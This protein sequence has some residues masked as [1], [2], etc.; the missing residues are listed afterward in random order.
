MAGSGR[1]WANGHAVALLAGVVAAATGLGFWFNAVVAFPLEDDA[2]AVV[3]VYPPLD[4]VGV[5]LV[6]AQDG[7]LAITFSEPVTL[8][9]GAVELSCERSLDHVVVTAGGPA[10]FSFVSDRLF[11]PGEVCRMT[12]RA[13]LIGDVDDDDPPDSPLSDVS[14]TFRTA[15]EPVIINELD[16][17]SA[18]GLGEFVELYDGGHGDTD[19]SGLTV[20]FYR[21]DEAV[22]YL[23]VALDDYRTNAAGYFVLGD[24]GIPGADLPLANGTL[25]DGPDAVAVY[26]APK[27]NFPRNTP[28]TTENLMD[29]VVYGPADAA[30]LVLLK[31][32]QAS[33]DEGGRGAATTDSLQRCPNGSGKPRETKAF[34]PN[35]PTP[36][37]S[38]RCSFDAAPS[39]VATTPL[40]GAASVPIDTS[41]GVDFSEAVTLASGAVAIDCE[42]SGSH[43]YAQS[44]SG[45][46]YSFKPDEPFV[47]GETCAVAI[48]AEL[49]SDNDV[50]DPPDYLGADVVWSFETI[51]PAADNVLIN[52]VDADTPG[53][54][55]VEFIELYDGGEG[56]TP[57]DGLVVVLVNGGDDSSYLTVSLDGYSTDA[58][59][60]FLLANVAVSG[61]GVTLVDGVLQNGPDAVVLVEGRAVDFP[62]GTP[63]GS[64]TPL[65]AFVY[66]RPDQT[67]TGLQLLLNAG[68]PQIDEN[69][70]G[71]GDSHSNQRCPN[72]AGGA[73]NTIGYRQNTPTPGTVNNCVTDTAPAISTM[74]PDRGATGVSIFTTVTVEFTESVSLAS[75]WLTIK[76]DNSGTHSYRT[77]GGPVSFSV[78]VDTALSY[79][80]KCT[81][82]VEAGKVADTDT[83]D[84]PDTMT[85]KV[86]WSFTT[87]DAPADFILINEVDADTP[88]SDTAEFIELFDGGV[89]NTVLDGLALVLFNG[90]DVL[91]YQAVDLDGYKTDAAGYFVI[92]NATTSPD[93]LLGNG[94]LQNGPDAAAIYVADAS[95]FPNGSLIKIAGLV[96]ALVYGDPATVPVAL[97]N[98]LAD[99]QKAVNEG[100]RGAADL[101]SMQRCPNGSGGARITESYAINS[102]MPGEP[103]SCEVD[104]PP[105][106]TGT[107][108]AGGTVD[109]S[110]YSSPEVSFSEPVQLTAGAIQLNCDPGGGRAIGI[111]G[112][113]VVFGIAPAQPLPYDAQC[114]VKISASGVTD[115]DA[116]D[117]P[118][119]MDEDYEWS[120]TTSSPPPDFVVINELDSDNPG[121][122]KAEFIELFDGGA[123]G[124]D[125]SGLV[126]VLYNGQDDRSYYAIDLDGGRTNE[127]G[128]LIIGN[129]GVVGISVEIPNSMLQNGPDAV[130]LYAGDATGFPNGTPIQLAGLIDAVV[131]G[132]ADPTDTGLLLL[133]ENGEPQVDEAAGGAADLHSIGRC[134]DG[135]GGKR[136]TSAIRIAIPSPGLANNCAMDAAPAVVDVKPPDGVGDVPVNAAI[137][138]EFSEAVTV[139]PGWV[140]ID[141][142]TSGEHSAQTEGGAT[143]F[144]ALPE[145]PLLPGERCAVTIRATAVAD[146]DNDDPPDNLASDFTWYFTTAVKPADFILINEMDADTPGA[147]EAEFIELYDGGVGN[148]SL[149]GLVV[150][151]WNGT[152]ENVYRAFDLDGNSTNGDGFFTLGNIAV[153]PGLVFD[154]DT[155]QNGPDA[156]TLFTG[157]ATDFPPGTQ[158]TTDDLIDAIVYGPEGEQA[159]ALLLLLSS[160]QLPVDEG[161]LGDPDA[162]S[163]QRCPDGSGGPRQTAGYRVAP[164]TPGGSNYCIVDDAPRVVDH[165]PVSGATDVALDATIVISFSEPVFTAAGWFTIDCDLSGAHAAAVTGGPSS[166]TLTPEIGF[167]PDEVCAV[168]VDRDAVKDADADDP[169]DGMI[170]DEVW[171][172][173]TRLPLPSAGFISNSPV[174]IGETVIFTNTSVGPGSLSFVWEFGDGSPL[175]NETNPSRRYASIGSYTV[176]LTVHGSTGIARYTALVEVR[177]RQ[178][179][180]GVVVR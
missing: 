23:A 75:K 145:V 156:V 93:L 114:R 82:T 115:V 179:Y 51:S 136:R 19:L 97:L 56:H 33:L 104:E 47:R 174:R 55:K 42:R 12:A 18:A 177:S 72:G 90:S 159:T 20:V 106:V 139:E 129:K 98:L 61:L 117:P 62:N 92:G 108:P 24:A 166:F 76:C 36:G 154:E 44:G 79:A 120:F 31:S 175:S 66:G 168:T 7:S 96:D 141:C 40:S 100:G 111:T 95:Q 9:A 163:L 50:E 28:V 13:D 64:I 143:Q 84:P 167:S 172:F 3:S 105:R 43:T 160:G 149:D 25:L 122:D 140:S 99:G 161:R 124:T 73:R 147:D 16:A 67:D 87:A 1:G 78:E 113:P 34:K 110:P 21:G 158:L 101:H 131:Y 107:I 8:G 2:P 70:R 128:F 10:I 22:V 165:W 15:A 134:P 126:L 171:T 94:S 125:L 14:S 59:G 103:N 41:I 91:S 77:T 46:S 109:V 38:N 6:V 4:A 88:G 127:G 146:L 89:G 48:H 135:G 173:H 132:T 49:V 118:D 138:V 169:P 80:E 39:V 69:G 112:G 148:T 57:L 45:I 53:V 170:T 27:S 119:G 157:T 35:T 178:L 86:S 116:S 5:P 130:A 155:L 176:T 81:L 144:T 123:G 83:H 102:P 68:Q 180:L 151:L 121:N 52:E 17:V 26:D 32:G 162:H 150:V 60:Y 137:E 164:P 29:A 85:Q 153:E 71:Q 54:D 152:T 142:E 58:A 74:S 65:D 37:E 133:L 63:V 30:L 11:M